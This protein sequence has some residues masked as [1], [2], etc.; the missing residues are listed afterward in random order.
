LRIASVPQILSHLHFRQ[1][2][3]FRKWWNQHSRHILCPRIS[4]IKQSPHGSQRNLLDEESAMRVS[5]EPRK[6][7]C[8]L[9]RRRFLARPATLEAHKQLGKLSAAGRE[10]AECDAVPRIEPVR[11]FCYRP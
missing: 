1:G 4:R 6:L 2:T 5:L 11:I 3:F 9:T 8:K 7:T 10:K